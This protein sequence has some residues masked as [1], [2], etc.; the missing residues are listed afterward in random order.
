M[1]I[2]E[3]DVMAALYVLPDDERFSGEIGVDTFRCL[4]DTVG[5]HG[6]TGA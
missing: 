5:V 4:F 2:V 6:Q 1:N 3:V